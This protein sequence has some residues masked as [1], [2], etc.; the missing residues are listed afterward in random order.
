MAR[1][2]KRASTSK[3]GLCL[4]GR[5]NVRTLVK[6]FMIAQAIILTVSLMFRRNIV[7]VIT[8]QWRVEE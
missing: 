5:E 4:V 2:A 1:I 7:A 6:L 3:N 8:L